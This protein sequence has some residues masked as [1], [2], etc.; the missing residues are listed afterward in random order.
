MPHFSYLTN[1]LSIQT[2][3]K[4][5]FMVEA[6][7]LSLPIYFS[8][9]EKND[10]QMVGMHSFVDSVRKAIEQYTHQFDIVVIPESRY[11]FLKDITAN[12]NNG[13]VLKKRT[14]A[15]ICNMAKTNSGWNK[16]E[17]SS[18]KKAWDEM[19]DSFTINKIKSNRRKDYIPYLFEKTNINDKTVV[20]LDDFVMSGNTIKAMELALGISE[21][22]T[23]CVFYQIGYGGAAT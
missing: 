18:A 15:E 22:Q 4:L 2:V 1:T 3:G 12:I 21:Y 10:Y 8:L 20:L 11:S 17:L 16:Q 5:S 6:S 7:N 14:K 23:L 9:K 13:F 19:G